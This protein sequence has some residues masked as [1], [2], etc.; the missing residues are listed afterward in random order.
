MESI[1]KVQDI[2]RIAKENNEVAVTLCDFQVMHGAMA[3]YREC[4]KNNIKPIFG[5]DINVYFNENKYNVLIYAKNDEGYKKMMQI[6][7]MLQEQEVTFD[8]L[9]DSNLYVCISDEYEYLKV[10]I[11]DSDYEKIKKE[12]T[13]IKQII[14]NI[15]I[16]ITNADNE[17]IAEKKYNFKKIYNELKIKTLAV[18]K[19]FYEH[20]EDYLYYRSLKAI[21]SQ[22]FYEDNKLITNP[23]RYYRTSLEL[24]KFY[25]EQDLKNTELLADSCNVNLNLEKATLPVYTQNNKVDSSTYLQKLCELGLQKRLNN[26]VS[27]NYKQRLE[28]ELKIINDMGFA[29]YFLIV[30]DFVNYAKKQK[31]NVGP[32]R[33]SAAGSLISYCLG[34]TEIDPIKYN[35]LFER[36]LNPERIS[37]PDIDIDFPD[38]RRDEV[39]QYVINKYGK[40]RVSHIVVYGCFKAKQALRDAGKIFFVNV[41]TINNLCSLIDSKKD[42][43]KSAYE[44]N[45][46][47]RYL[48]DSSKETK[49]MYEVALFLEGLPRHISTHPAGIVISKNPISEYSPL[50]KIDEDN[51]A[52]QFSVNYLEE[53]GLIK[54]D[55]LGLKNLTIIDEI[56]EQIG[57]ININKIPLDDQKTFKLLSQADTVGIFQLES[58]GIKNVL[59]K[60]KPKKFDE[61]ATV[62]ALYRPGPMENI[63]TYLANRANHEN[64]DYLH[65][66]LKPILESTYGIMI[67]QEQIMQIAQTMAG[68]SLGKA[69]ILRKAI[70]KKQL[71][72]MKKMRLE[73]QEGALKKGYS[74]EI[75]DQ[76]FDQILKFAGYG[77]NKAHAVSY[78]M[79]VYQLSYLKAN[80]PAEFYTALLNGVIGDQKKT[81]EYLNEAKRKGLTILSPSINY[82]TN[83]YY[84]SDNNIRIPLN[85]IKGL[86]VSNIESILKERT[87]NGLYVDYDNFIIRQYKLGS[88]N[89]RNLIYA[90]A[91]D[92]FG[93]N[94]EY[95]DDNLEL[96][97]NYAKMIGDNG[98]SGFD[99]IFD[100]CESQPIKENIY[101]KLY[102]EYSVLGFYLSDHPIKV[103]RDELGC[104]FLDSSKVLEK[105]N[106]SFVGKLIRIKRHKTK[107]GDDMAFLTLED[108]MGYLNAILMPDLYDSN[109]GKLELNKIYQLKG[110]KGKKESVIIKSIKKDGN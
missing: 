45:K 106:S 90:G 96:K 99:G 76:V 105:E 2:V 15:L 50:I 84:V 69:D 23:N 97:F 79:I 70:S 41:G 42:N 60:L 36:F 47:F 56:V 86:G 38:N 80:Y 53:L 35:L 88:S 68:F 93:F 63:D 73:F 43:L 29:D 21:K 100:E 110:K 74:Q 12:L 7:T 27:S 39:I 44:E 40:T 104:D 16:A 48:I 34:I 109:I 19:I 54:M 91:L 72:M 83:K 31:I 20:S 94:R 64:I 57:D 75:I 103:R 52:T 46:K 95:L 71:D 28:Y 65:K 49:K 9:K 8:L 22:T 33:G 92:T 62:L 102:N 59:R 24:S 78:G 55:F 82:S 5:M 107:N 10:L 18:N 26:K 6:S 81:K 67:Y 30:Y 101:R 85:V 11:E 3:F 25:E 61:I 98:V 32:G 4:Q 14:P 37:M 13:G 17:Y 89:I 87:A 77:F 58:A 51:Y 66:D 108:D 1:L